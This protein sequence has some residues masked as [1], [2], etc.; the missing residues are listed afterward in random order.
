MIVHDIMTTK[1]ITVAPDDTLA[2]AANLLRQYRFHYEDRDYT[3]SSNSISGS[4]S[5]SPRRAIQT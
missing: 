2:H 5:T 4:G 3:A 1:L